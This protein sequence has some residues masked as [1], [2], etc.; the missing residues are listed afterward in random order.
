MA[1][2]CAM[3]EKIVAAD[4]FEDKADSLQKADA[5]RIVRQDPCLHTVQL[6]FIKNDFQHF[7]QC[8]RR[9]SPM[10]NLA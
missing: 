1:L 8:L 10:M 5:W 4:P 3:Q 7:G 2:P 6:Q 9:I